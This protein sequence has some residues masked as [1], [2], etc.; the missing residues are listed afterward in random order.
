MIPLPNISWISATSSQKR[1]SSY[2]ILYVTSFDPA[3]KALLVRRVGD[4]LKPVVLEPSHLQKS[5]FV[6]LLTADEILVES[7]RS[8]GKITN[9]SSNNSE[10]NSW[11]S[12]NLNCPLKSKDPVHIYLLSETLDQHDLYQIVPNWLTV[13]EWIRICLR[14]K[15]IDI[16]D[17]RYFWKNNTNLVELFALL[18]HC[19]LCQAISIT[20]VFVNKNHLGIG[21]FH[22]NRAV[23]CRNWICCLA[24]HTIDHLPWP[25]T[26]WSC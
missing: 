23:G 22:Y 5:L 11:L 13:R 16:G 2:R 3:T 6:M 25:F 1:G 24:N 17:V 18:C 7:P 20:F 15:Q 9:P 4:F 26:D 12:W 21:W 8:W 10:R 14:N 19:S